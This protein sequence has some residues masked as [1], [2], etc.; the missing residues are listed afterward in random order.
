[1]KTINSPPTKFLGVAEK[2]DTTLSEWT[3]KVDFTIVWID[4]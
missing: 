3:V 1:M 4:D 2:V